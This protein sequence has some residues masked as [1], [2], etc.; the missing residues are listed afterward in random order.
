MVESDVLVLT[1]VNP[2]H[3]PIHEPWLK[4]AELSK[5]RQWMLENGR[6]PTLGD[7]MFVVFPHC[8]DP[9]LRRH[10]VR[11]PLELS[12]HVHEQVKFFRLLYD[13]CTHIDVGGE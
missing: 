13:Q 8:L 5:E 11:D 12:T 7:E 2:F 4:L 9:P 6:R 3:D 1:L 10:L